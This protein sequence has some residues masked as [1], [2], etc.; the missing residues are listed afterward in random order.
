LTDPN[1]LNPEEL[2]SATV[3]SALPLSRADSQS[4][5][6]ALYA[7]HRRVLAY[8]ATLRRLVLH[9]AESGCNREAQVVSHGVLRFFD[10]EIPQHYAD[11]E[12]DLFPALIDSMAGSDAVCLQA[13]TRG[14][15]EQHRALSAQWNLLR[16]P[17][18]EIAAGRRGFL[19][20]ES[21]EAFTK[22]W[23]DHIGAEE[24]EL[25]PMASR[26]LTDGDLA[27]VNRAMRVRRT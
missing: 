5:L 6:S 18:E 21:V 15:A 9:V 22:L 25:L 1:A 3:F 4:P 8:C 12:E 17:L 27:R 16:E 20:C 24:G 2:M 13:L 14:S 10:N 26:L 11:E 23:H 7:C 19:S